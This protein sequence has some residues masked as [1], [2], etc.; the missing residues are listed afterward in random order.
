MLLFSSLDWYMDLNGGVWVKW[1]GL[2]RV[3]QLY[4]KVGFVICVGDGDNLALKN[5]TSSCVRTVRSIT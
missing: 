5:A 1:D 3:Q 2:S 4:I